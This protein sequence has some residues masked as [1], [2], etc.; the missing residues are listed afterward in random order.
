MKKKNFRSDVTD[1]S[2]T[3]TT[4]AHTP[5][6]LLKAEIPARSPQKLFIFIL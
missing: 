5:G 6:V 2:A 1:V 3:E 4:A